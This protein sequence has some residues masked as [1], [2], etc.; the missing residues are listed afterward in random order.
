MH[1]NID[2]IN[3]HYISDS[4]NSEFVDQRQYNPWDLILKYI[5]LRMNG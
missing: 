1:L 4:L 3:A 2:F 5:V